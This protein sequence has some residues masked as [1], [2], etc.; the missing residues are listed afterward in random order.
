MERDKSEKGYNSKKGI[1]KVEDSNHIFDFAYTV[2]KVGA[3][4]WDVVKH[5]LKWTKEVYRMLGLEPFSVKAS[6]EL[7]L[8]YV[9]PDDRKYFDTGSGV[10]WDEKEVYTLDYRVIVNNKTR[11]FNSTHR[12]KCDCDGNPI[13]IAGTVQDV[14]NRK[15]IEN[16]LVKAKERAEE[17]NF[18]KTK[19]LNNISHEV[20]TPMNGIIGFSNLLV[21]SGLSKEKRVKYTQI[22]QN[23]GNQLLRI[24]DDIIEISTLDTKQEKLSESSFSLNELLNDIFSIFSLKVD[25]E[26]VDF[27]VKSLLSDKDSIIFSDKVKLHRIMSNITENAIKFTKK[28]FVEMGYNIENDKLVLYVKDTGIGVSSNR[29]PEIFERFS[30]ENKNTVKTYGGLGLGLSISKENAK[31]LGGEITVESQKDKGSMFCLTIPYKP[32][33]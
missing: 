29:L 33:S 25:T 22:I 2:G 3:W 14:T 7:L 20:R 10:V 8:T 6:Q 13:R 17:A 24:I 16:E 19:F 11:I 18:L 26:E 32:I 27:R 12:V 23:S 15:E 1:E 21:K 31:L 28:G 5:E 9:H 4:D 30:Q